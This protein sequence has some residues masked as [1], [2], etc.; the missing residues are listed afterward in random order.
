MTIFLIKG[1]YGGIFTI[2]KRN[3]NFAI[4]RI[5]GLFHNDD[6]T[7]KNSCINHTIAFYIERKKL[8]III[9]HRVER[10]IIDNIFN[11]G[12]WLASSYNSDKGDSHCILP[13]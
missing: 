12:N 7:I 11:S 5:V 9:F 13:S 6:V 8:I 2:D 10:Y 1:F 3:D 4:V